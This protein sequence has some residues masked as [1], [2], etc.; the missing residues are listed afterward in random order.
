MW[1]RFANQCD[2]LAVGDADGSLH[3]FDLR[4]GK[5]TAAFGSD[6]PPNKE[7]WQLKWCGRIHAMN[8]FDLEWSSDDAWIATGGVDNTVKIVCGKTFA[9]TRVLHCNGPV[10]GVAWNPA[11]TLLTAQVAISLEHSTASQPAGAVMVW[12]AS[13]WSP[14]SVPIPQRYFASPGEQPLYMRHSWSPDGQWCMLASAKLPQ[15]S[16]SQPQGSHVAAWCRLDAQRRLALDN[17][18]RGELPRPSPMR[19]QRLLSCA[20]HIAL[21]GPPQTTCCTHHFPS[22]WSALLFATKVTRSRCLWRDSGLLESS[23]TA[24]LCLLTVHDC[25]LP[26]PGS[27]WN[28]CLVA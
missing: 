13:T 10:K 28:T 14:V 12:D 24:R 15:L 5:P 18:V 2:L 27:L 6:A 16:P 3:I 26:L 22:A 8:I 21:P 7:N 1:S 25:H 23:C 17:H 9:Q 20:V 19:T 11:C 4:D